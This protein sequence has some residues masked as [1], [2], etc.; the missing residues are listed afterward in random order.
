MPL[1]SF[2]RKQR[3]VLE[4]FKVFLS[5]LEKYTRICRILFVVIIS[6]SG[7]LGSESAHSQPIELPNLTIDIE[8]KVQ[9]KEQPPRRPH[10]FRT[11]LE[12]GI[13]LGGATIWYW[14][15]RERQVADW[16]YDSL[17]ER[18]SLDAWR[19]DNNPFDINY[20]WHGIAGTYY[21]ALARANGFSTNSSLAVSFFTSLAW[22]Y[23]FEFR[24]KISIVDVIYT[25]ASGLTFGE[26]FHILGLSLQQE[27]NPSWLTSIAR[28]TVGFPVSLHQA[29]DK[30]TPH[31]PPI[32]KRLSFSYHLMNVDTKTTKVESIENNV[33]VHGISFDG[34][35]STIPNYLESNDQKSF[36]Y[37]TKLLYLQADL[38][39]SQNSPNAFAQKVSMNF[40]SESYLLGY[41]WQTAGPTQKALTIG[42]SMATQYSDQSFSSWHDQISVLHLP[43]V[44]LNAHIGHGAL[45]IRAELRGNLDF[46]GIL[47][48]P[49]AQW[50]NDNPS[51]TTETSIVRKS[52]YYYGYGR[53]LR[54]LLEANI[55]PF[56][57]GT[58]LYWGHYDSIEGLGRKQEEITHDL[59]FSDSI[60]R[61]QGWLNF[62]PP[63]SS[64]YLGF[65]MG[66]NTWDAT[67]Y[68]KYSASQKATAVKAIFGVA[69]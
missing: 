10:Y 1:F 18:F 15:D 23:L 52:G 65:H 57:L 2:R 20:F 37:G 43:G 35:I 24:E 67:L 32:W 55:G 11:G 42:S 19:F 69:Y 68:E 63:S 59:E 53:S 58:A 16:D 62:R 47:A 14:L 31:F 6:A 45:Q 17:G 30:K 38:N 4:I 22:E 25:P 49:Y 39:F 26:F 56:C 9:P 60:I 27:K 46:A 29:L 34:R 8:P 41:H 5:L 44:A 21:Y 13:L 12:M 3:S 48:L 64:Y 7:F 54:M 66:S 50:K 36:F 28:W 51:I 40:F 61:F 33:F